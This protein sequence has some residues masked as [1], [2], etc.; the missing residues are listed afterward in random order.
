MRRATL[1]VSALLIG[2]AIVAAPAS[3]TPMAKTPGKTTKAV[4]T[5][6]KTTKTSTT[7]KAATSTSPPPAAAPSKSVAPSTVAPSGVVNYLKIL[8]AAGSTEADLGPNYRFAV[9]PTNPQ[10]DAAYKSVTESVAACN[11]FPDVIPNLG[12]KGKATQGWLYT[13]STTGKAVPHVVVITADDATAHSVLESIRTFA[14]FPACTAGFNEGQSLRTAVRDN[15]SLIGKDVR[16]VS[17]N[18]R[19]GPSLSG[20]GDDQVTVQFEQTLFVDG[21][22]QPVIALA[23]HIARIGPAI[24][25]YQDEASAAAV[26][27]PKLADKLRA[28]LKA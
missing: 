20:L 10:N 27:A 1:R 19:F 17:T 18:A 25:E 11:G 3:G 7:Q 26:N 13:N 15:P 22:A 6:A 21:V 23:K 9:D 16:Y 14:S 2:A 12:G 24:L 4:K 8:A 5:Q 28:A